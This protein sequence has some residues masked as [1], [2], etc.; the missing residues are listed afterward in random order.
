M[1]F[2]ENALSGRIDFHVNLLPDFARS[3]VSA[4]AI[5]DESD[6]L[7]HCFDLPATSKLNATC[8]TPTIIAAMDRGNVERSVVFSYQWKN[9][10]RC[11]VANETVAAAVL[12]NRER[13]YG[14]A[15]VQPRDRASV[16]D[17]ERLLKLPNM[18]GVKMKPRWGGF[19][20]SDIDL[21]AP[22]CELLIATDSFLL[23]HVSQGFHK[24][25]GDQISDLFALMMN[26]PKLNVVAAHMAGFAGVYEC[27]Q[28]A[29]KLM[30]R[31]WVDVSLPSNLKWLPHLM[32]LGNPERYLYATDWP[33]TDYE[34][35]DCLLDE[36][37]LTEKRK[38]SP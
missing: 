28:P 17:L 26:F 8:D 7:R 37:G 13:L 25:T 27:Y 34:K 19:A 16:D 4:A 10:E 3:N 11:R 38:A 29:K 30:D 35:F 31:L 15:V 5:P 1:N 32:R 36:V 6:H 21:M 22:I 2:W 33:Y 23:T 20:L 24:P 14:L 18:Y 9:P 12:A